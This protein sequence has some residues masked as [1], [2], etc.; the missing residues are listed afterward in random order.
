MPSR[1]VSKEDL[2][3]LHLTRIY[4]RD[5][6]GIARKLEWDLDDGGLFRSV[7]WALT[8]EPT[9]AEQAQLKHLLG[10]A[11]SRVDGVYI[12]TSFKENRGIA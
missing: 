4:G 8:R 11:F 5:Y 6:Q 3:D 12:L 2:I 7:T 1:Y 10:P 9:R